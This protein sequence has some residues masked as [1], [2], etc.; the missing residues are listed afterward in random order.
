MSF[1]AFHRFNGGFR[2]SS[3]APHGRRIYDALKSSQGNTYDE[4]FDGRQS[5]RLYAASMSLAAAQYQIDRALNNASPLTATELL[6][7]I[8]RDYQIVPNY[9]QTL[10]DRREM[11]DARRKVTRG[12]RRESIE[13]AL[14]V[15][16]GDDFVDYETTAASDRVTWPTLPEDVGAFKRAGAPKKGFRLLGNVSRLNVDLTVSFEAIPGLDAPVAGDTYT[17]ETDSRSPSTERITILSVAASTITCQFTK[18]HAAGALAMSPHPVWIS[19]QRYDRIVTTF[20]AAT[21]QETRRKIN[22]VMARMLRGVSQ[23]CIVS[24]EGGFHLGSA[25]RARLDAT[26]LT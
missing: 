2:F 24:D 7:K 5:A 17:L 12:A 10:Q 11:A 26:R 1:S 3:R 16:L 14:R 19:N 4:S 8:E 9:Q 23:W 18:P 25:T 22:E 13:D 20:A 6:G 15:L 21:N